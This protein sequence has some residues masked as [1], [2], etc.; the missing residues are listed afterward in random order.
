MPLPLILPRGLLEI[1]TLE[2]K[3]HQTPSIQPSWLQALTPEQF[4]HP[5]TPNGLLK[6][7]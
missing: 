7:R 5:A 1:S 3:T 2:R 6:V 4:K